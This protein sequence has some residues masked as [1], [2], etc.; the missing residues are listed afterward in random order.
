MTTIRIDKL[1]KH[2]ADHHALNDVSLE[3]PSG[4]LFALLG[5]SGCGK[6]TLLRII[7]GLEEA[8]SGA[9]YFDQEQIDHVPVEKRHIGIVFQHY[10]LFPHMTVFQNVAFGLRAQGVDAPTIQERVKEALDLVGLPDKHSRKTPDLSG[11]E[12]QRVALAR[13]IV[14]KPRVLLFDE[15]LSNLDARL[16]IET[17]HAIRQLV[18]ELAITSIFVTHD[19]EEAMSLADH[20]AVMRDGEILQHG[21]PETCYHEST[22]EFVGRFLGRANIIQCNNDIRRHCGF[23]TSVERIIIRPEHLT[24]S[25]EPAQFQGTIIDQEF[26]GAQR[27]LYVQCEEHGV[28]ELLLDSKQNAPAVGSS[29]HLTFAPQFGRALTP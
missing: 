26:Q 7:A 21:S 12:Q 3:I 19:Q 28:L 15:P 16:R 8:D 1:H 9:I 13:A 10:A 27:R 5:P 29:V 20:M 24:L 6:T 4:S 23:T 2:F 11:G 17:R 14:I 18:R 25:P 22:N